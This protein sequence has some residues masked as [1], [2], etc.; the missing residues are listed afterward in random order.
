[1]SRVFEADELNA[2]ERLLGQRV[3]IP[4]N[5]PYFKRKIGIYRALRRNDEYVTIMFEHI[6]TMIR[7][8]N[9]LSEEMYK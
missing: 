3:R 8:L 9:R 1:M 7:M 2:I 4:G 5:K 6:L